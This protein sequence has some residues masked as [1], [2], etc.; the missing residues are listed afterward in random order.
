MCS[1]D[2]SSFTFLGAYQAVMGM[3]YGYWGVIIGVALAGL[4]YVVI[5]LIIKVSGSAWVNR[6]DVY[7]RQ[8]QYGKEYATGGVF[9]AGGL[10][11]ILAILIKVLGTKSVMKPVSYTH[12]DVYKRQVDDYIPTPERKADLP[13]LMPI[14]DVFTITGRG[15][16][17]LLYTSCRAAGPCGT[18]CP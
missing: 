17:C 12:L 9:A 4:V 15:T 3:N 2:L 13:F 1:S 7:K 16:V 8:P 11:V 14:E 10:Y 6:L 5:A 18:G